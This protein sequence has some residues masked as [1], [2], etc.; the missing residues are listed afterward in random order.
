MSVQQ[1]PAQL[2]TMV[3]WV[4]L[5]TSARLTLD[6]NAHIER[7][8]QSPI[9]F[10]ASNFENWDRR[11]VKRVDIPE[12]PEAKYVKGG[13]YESIKTPEGREHNIVAP[14]I[15]PLDNI[16]LSSDFDN[17]PLLTNKNGLL[18]VF[19]PPAVKTNDLTPNFDAT[20]Q[21][22]SDFIFKNR[23]PRDKSQSK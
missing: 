17:L 8:L 3:N 12:D 7:H 4:R 11:Q 19:Q 6:E 13:A 2:K 20:F 18:K 22:P 21:L 1:E 14:F 23:T 5:L 15:E 9:I 16:K 10:K